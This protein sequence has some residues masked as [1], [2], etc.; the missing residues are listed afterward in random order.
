M[1]N[2]AK[3]IKHGR[4][5]WW[6]WKGRESETWVPHRV[7]LSSLLSCCSISLVCV[8]RSNGTRP[9]KR[10]RLVFCTLL[11]E[12]L[13]LFSAPPQVPAS[14]IPPFRPIQGECKHYTLLWP[15][16]SIPMVSHQSGSWTYNG[17][18]LRRDGAIKKKKKK[19]QNCCARRCMDEKASSSIL[20]NSFYSY[21]WL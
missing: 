8:W 5:V 18:G 1:V 20:R 12:C 14:R 7:A 17:E 15:V 9:Y 19:D 11:Y 10:T 4:R 21:S 13:A 2:A 3:P 16:E 6:W